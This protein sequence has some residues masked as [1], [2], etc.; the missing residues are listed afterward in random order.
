MSTPCHRLPHIDALKALAAQVIV[1]H[2]LVSYGPIAQAAHDALPLLAGALHDYG[3][4][5][6][7]VFLVVGGYL[8]ARALSPRGGALQADVP[9]L[10]WRRY[11]RLVLP[12]LAALALTL[13]ACGLIAS[14]L[15]ELLPASISAAQLLAHALLL[16]DVLDHEALTVGA[17]YVAIDLQLFAVLVGLLWLAR[18]GGRYPGRHVAGPLLVA[19]VALAS[20]FVFNL[21]PALDDWAPYFFAAYGL[22]AL[23]HWLGLWRH[24]RAG[25]VLLTLA[26]A[27]ALMLDWRDRLALALAT[28][29]WLAWAQGRRAAGRAALPESW[30]P[31]LA[32]WARPS[33]ALF[34][35]HFA[36]LLLMN[37]LLANVDEAT[38]QLG[39]L[40]LVLTWALANWLA[41]PFY[42]W[43]EVPAARFDPLAWLPRLRT[44]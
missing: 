24:R 5:A 33:Y 26:M 19:G 42:R 36:V 29:L 6:V 38:P 34:L 9:A 25:L 4:M 7:Q 16:H 8:S 37:A 22:G 13:G 35:L 40:L 14:S 15:P 32:A 43:V 21:D 31:A 39:L 30:A 10:L 28:A 27:A 12:F 18:R 41:L 1:L 20:A 11:L 23:V 3:R 17:W 44:A 2:H